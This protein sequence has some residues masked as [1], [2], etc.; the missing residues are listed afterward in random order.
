MT[1]RQIGDASIKE[2]KEFLKPSAN[3]AFMGEIIQLLA[4]GDTSKCS[5]NINLSLGLQNILYCSL[6]HMTL[7]HL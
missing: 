3:V 2:S 6:E 4:K 5:H 7:L 1:K